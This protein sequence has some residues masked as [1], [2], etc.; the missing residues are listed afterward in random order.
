MRSFICLF[1]IVLLVLPASRSFAQFSDGM[2]FEAPPAFG[3]NN[4]A[5]RKLLIIQDQNQLLKKIIEREKSVNSM[6]SAAI[7]VGISS[8]FVPAPDQAL[9]QAVPANIPC[10]QAYPSL[11]DDFK[12]AAKNTPTAMPPASSMVSSGEIPSLSSDDFSELPQQQAE[13]APAGQIYWMD[14]TCMSARCSAVLSS[15]P[16]DPKTRYRI[17]AGET[18]PDGSIVRTI[19]YS[20][21]TIERDKKSVQLEPAPS[22]S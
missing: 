21:V 15:N 7:D 13:A 17:L 20:G 10:A 8:P 18:L 19:S 16:Q 3:Q 5:L 6:V 11:Y 14:I 22:A 1:L 12:I 4:P 9:C 2:D